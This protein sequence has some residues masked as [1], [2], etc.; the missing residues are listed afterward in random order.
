MSVWV[1]EREG[2]VYM[3]CDKILTLWNRGRQTVGSSRWRRWVCCCRTGVWCRTPPTG[4]SW[5]WVRRP[6]TPPNL[7]PRSPT[8]G[9][10]GRL[11]TPTP[12]TQQLVYN[13]HDW[14]LKWTLTLR[15]DTRKT[16]DSSIPVLAL[17]LILHVN[18][19]FVSHFTQWSL[20]SSLKMCQKWAKNY[21]LS[22]KID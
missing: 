14:P 20:T 9:T 19:Y 16:H 13:I 1:R 7:C 22:Q 8:C 17:A 10:N 4:T 12:Q 2:G 3:P 5:W 18:E 11:S 15:T 6:R 21:Y